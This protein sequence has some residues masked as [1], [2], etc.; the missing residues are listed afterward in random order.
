MS[1][2]TADSSERWAGIERPYGTADVERLRG[3]FH[4]EHTLAR[5]GLS[6]IHI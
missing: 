2:V 4:V 5:L 3:R 1:G 6:L